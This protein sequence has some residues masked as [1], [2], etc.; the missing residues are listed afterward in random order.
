MLFDFWPIVVRYDRAPTWFAKRLAK[1]DDSMYPC[2]DIGQVR[3]KTPR[4]DI[5]H[6]FL[7]RF[8]A[9]CSFTRVPKLATHFS[10]PI[11]DRATFQHFLDTSFIPFIARSTERVYMSSNS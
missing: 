3:N 7:V 5:T 2:M 11:L 4:N 8:S 6:T 1:V 9:E 10:H